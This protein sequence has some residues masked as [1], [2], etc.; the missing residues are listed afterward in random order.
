VS[1]LYTPLWPLA[2]LVTGLV[3]RRWEK[4]QAMRLRSAEV[5]RQLYSLPVALGETL[6][7]KAACEKS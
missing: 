6:I 3:F 2:W 1:W 7:V 4:D 5:R